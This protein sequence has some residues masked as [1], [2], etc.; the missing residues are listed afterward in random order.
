MQ[1]FIDR[2]IEWILG[3]KPERLS[4]NESFTT[5]Q[6]IAELVR[7]KNIDLFF[8][9]DH[10]NERRHAFPEEVYRFAAFN[11]WFS[12]SAELCTFA[13]DNEAPGGVGKATEVVLYGPPEGIDAPY[14][15]Y[16][17]VSNEMLSEIYETCRL[18]PNDPRADIFKVLDHC[19][20]KG[21]VY[22][23]A[24]PVDGH[25]L[26]FRPTLKILSRVKFAEA[27]NGGHSRE[28][29]LL[30]SS[31]IRL[32]NLICRQE[33]LIEEIAPR[34]TLFQRSM[35]EEIRGKEPI[36]GL[37]ASDAHLS[38]YDRVLTLFHKGGEEADIGELLSYM[39]E[40]PASQIMWE[41]GLTYEGRPIG[42]PAYMRDVVTLIVRNLASNRKLF[43]SI[44][45]VASCLWRMPRVVFGELARRRRA[46]KRFL[47][48]LKVQMNVKRLLRLVRRAWYKRTRLSHSKAA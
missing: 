22:C 19:D 18:G 5:L 3:R 32:H 16:H 17:G 26:S 34:I 27:L 21:Y 29:M 44:F 9:T 46:R 45:I 15:H 20:R 14:G 24:H 6:D 11:P 39:Q 33:R 42:F 36:V 10:V 40:T 35:L 48:Q 23:L 47:R 7:E 12:A 25:E 30:V 13:A 38:N 37:G 1:P 8:L 2:N 28:S 43:T 4:W 31:Y 41:R